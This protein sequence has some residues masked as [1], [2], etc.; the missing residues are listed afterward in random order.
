[1]RVKRGDCFY[2]S[3]GGRAR[4]VCGGKAICDGECAPAAFISNAYKAGERVSVYLEPFLDAMVGPIE[5]GGVVV[6]K[7]VGPP[8]VYE[9]EIKAVYGDVL[10]GSIAGR[11]LVAENKPDSVCVRR[12]I[13]PCYVYCNKRAKHIV[14][15]CPNIGVLYSHRGSKEWSKAL[16]KLGKIVAGLSTG[17]RPRRLRRI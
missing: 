15:K 7:G 5:P 1:M 4:V 13:G 8:G 10:V 9:V 11:A 17:M 12:R 3:R 16:E 6:A 2:E 14:V